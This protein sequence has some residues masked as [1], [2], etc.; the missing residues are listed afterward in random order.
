MPTVPSEPTAQRAQLAMRER[1]GAAGKIGHD[2]VF[3]TEGGEPFAT[4]FLPYHRWRE[5]METL[6]VR[7]RKPYNARHTYH[8]VETML[9]TYA[10][11]IK[12]AKPEDIERIKRAMGGPTVDRRYWR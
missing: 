12:G 9:R 3:F 10:G 8:S 6:S 1:M 2:R 11:W 7:Y 5:V 4:V